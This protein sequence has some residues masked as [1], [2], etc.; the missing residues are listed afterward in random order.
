MFK[1]SSYFESDIY[2]NKKICENQ[3]KP[4]AINVKNVRDCTL[5]WQPDFSNMNYNATYSFFVS[6]SDQ[7]RGSSIAYIKLPS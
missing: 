5:E 7:F 2:Q 3:I 6:C 1:V 4:P